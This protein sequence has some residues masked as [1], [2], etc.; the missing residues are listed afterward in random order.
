MLTTSKKP[1]FSYLRRIMGL[2]LLAGVICLF[3]FTLKSENSNESTKKIIAVKPFKLVVDAGH[4]GK[5]NGAFGNGLYEKDITLKIA[6]KIKA[7]STQYGIDVMLTRSGDVFMSPPEKS[8]FANAQNANAFVSIHVNASPNNKP[9]NSGMEVVLSKR[10]EQTLDNSRILGSAIIQNLQPDF[11]ITPSLLQKS[12]G[13][14]VLENSNIPAVLIEC[15]HITNADDA[16]LL[17]DDSKI[18]LLAKEILSGAAMFANN[19]NIIL[20]QS[21]IQQENDTSVPVKKINTQTS[22][23]NIK[24]IGEGTPL[25]LVDGV[26]M[27]SNEVQT[28]LQKADILSINVWRG[29]SAI[30]KF[31]EKGKNGVV[32]IVSKN[33]KKKPGAATFFRRLL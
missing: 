27:S 30:A 6:E 1:Q 17:Q 26:E 21:I 25:Y 8:E 18:E 2:P 16:K 15:G 32:E 11:R 14:W 4:G 9:P 33:D 28:T 31:G 10:N 3:A 20:P 7:L 23:V 29:D 22:Q 19:K 13:I 5:D 12:V 24:T